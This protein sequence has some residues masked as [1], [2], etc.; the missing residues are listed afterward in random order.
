MNRKWTNRI[1]FIM[2]ECMPSFIRNSKW[3]MYPFYYYAYRG[4]NIAAAMDFK[5]NY[6]KWT[7][8]ELQQFYENIQSVSTNRPTDIS[9]NGLKFIIDQCTPDIASVLDIGCGKGYLLKLLHKHYPNLQL[10][11][12]DFVEH[13][14]VAEFPFTKADAKNLP[15][16][17]RSFDLVVCTHTIEHIYEADQLVHELKRIAKK[18]LIVITPK[19]RYFYYTL[20]EHI[21]FFPE[22][23]L[24]TSLI[25][26]SNYTCTNID[27]DW[28][29][30]GYLQ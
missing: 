15:I 16:P 26:M 14:G 30:T 10:H 1:R 8:A 23:E 9:P 6:F 22:K 29:Y 20:D 11:G 24:L 13:A 27:G 5:K 18:K 21:N 25:N 4:H 17:D 12:A 28:V 7:P 19:Q 3:F 2:D